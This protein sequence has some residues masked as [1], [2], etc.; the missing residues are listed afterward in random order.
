MEWKLTE[1]TVSV[2]VAGDWKVRAKGNEGLTVYIVIAGVD[3]FILSE[4]APGT[5]AA[6]I[7]SENFERGET[8]SYHFSDR[9]GGPDLAPEWSGTAVDPRGE[10]TVSEDDPWVMVCIISTVIILVII[11][12]VI[13]AIVM[14]VRR[15]EDEGWDEE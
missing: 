2:L 9:E 11:G 15:K 1:V 12:L 8:Y 10:T 6:N 7:F 5:Y 4:T 14:A 13:V 3:S